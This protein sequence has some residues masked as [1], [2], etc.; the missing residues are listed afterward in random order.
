MFSEAERLPLRSNGDAR[1]ADAS[2]KPNGHTAEA[3]S[4][5]TAGGPFMI[6][7]DMKRQLR[8]MGYTADQ[9]FNMR[10]EDAQ[11]ILNAAAALISGQ[12]GM[13]KTFI[14]IDLTAAGMTGTP[15]FGSEID[16]R[17]AVIRGGG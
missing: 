1:K 11:Q 13:F 4:P 10:P 14:A 3:P 16:R 7:A 9:I 12:W 6:T 15:I 8:E 17:G 2:A 5:S